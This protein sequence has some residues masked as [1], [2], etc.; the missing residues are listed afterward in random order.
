MNM[1]SLEELEMRMAYQDDAIAQLSDMVYA[2]TQALDRLSERC[3]A[4]ESRV[5]S[6]ADDAGT[7]EADDA[8]PP[9]Y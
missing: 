7:P 6:L 1:S 3:R 9:H 8:P 5:Q 4:L 2:Q